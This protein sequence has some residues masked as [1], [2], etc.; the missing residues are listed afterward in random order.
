MTKVVADTELKLLLRGCREALE[1]CDEA[2]R[3]LGYYHPAVETPAT[4]KT[5]SPFPIEE[6]ER[7]E[8]EAGGTSLQEILEKLGAS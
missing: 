6:L 7:R 8:R 2:G 5:C 3:T 1:V 4:S